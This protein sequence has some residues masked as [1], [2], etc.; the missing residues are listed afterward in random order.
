MTCA[1]TRERLATEMRRAFQ[2]TEHRTSAV[3]PALVVVTAALTEQL[4]PGVT[5]QTSSSMLNTSVNEPAAI[6]ARY[7][8]TQRSSGPLEEC[9]STNLARRPNA[10]CSH[11]SDVCMCHSVQTCC[12]YSTR[13]STRQIS[14]RA[15]CSMQHCHEASFA[16]TPICD[17]MTTHLESASVARDCCFLCGKL[18]PWSSGALYITLNNIGRHRLHEFLPLRRRE[19]LNVAKHDQVVIWH[20]VKGSASYADVLHVQY[21]PPHTALSTPSWTYLKQLLSAVLDA[22]CGKIR[23]LANRC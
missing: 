20:I 1:G 10:P 22:G 8:P 17:R 5:F 12:M 15:T 21:T 11:S 13:I 9:G 18:E 23:G 7:K 19:N 2:Q 4:K 14:G 16:Y 6:T 3:P